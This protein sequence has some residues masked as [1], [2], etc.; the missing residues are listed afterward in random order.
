MRIPKMSVDDG[1]T[2]RVKTRVDLE[3][4]RR[5]ELLGQLEPDEMDEFLGLATIQ[6][7]PADRVIFQKAD[8]GDRLF[9][10]ISGRVGITTESESGKSILLNM[11]KVGDVL[12]EIAL[13]D[14][15][16]R[17]A[18]AVALDESELLCVERPDF[19]N[20]LERH[21]RLAIRL[22]GVL[23]DRLRW[24]SDIIEDT[25]FLDI[26]HRL[27]KRLLVLSDQ[28][29][30]ETD[31]GLLIDLRLSQESLGQMLGAT[32]ESI[33]KGLKL[34]EHK[35]MIGSAGGYIH[36]RDMDALRDFGGR[37]KFD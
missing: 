10:I 37:D 7:Y 32:R 29:G 33:N 12:G 4:L 19:L 8:P 35:G 2:D 28:Y 27:A 17:T 23:C 34:L 22:M 14:G 13:L 24:T 26:P 16:P 20:F 21:P 5:N 25:I 9:A 1:V 15:K 3:A 30:R 36:V 18:N 6:T 31:D 11:L